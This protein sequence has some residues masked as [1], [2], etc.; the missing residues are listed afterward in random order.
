MSVIK[1][2]R[3][4]SYYVVI[5]F[6][7]AYILS[8][9][10]RMVLTIVVDKIK[11]DLA[12][13]EV[14]VSLLLGF[15]FAVSYII[16]GIPFGRWADSRS[17]V[18]LITFGIT[19][20]TIATVACGFAGSFW[21]LFVARIFVGFGEAAL[22]PAVYSLL[23]DYFRRDRVGFAMAIFASGT[24]VGGGLGLLTAGHIIEQFSLG[25]FALPMLPNIKSWQFAFIAVAIPGLVVAPLVW[26]TIREPARLGTKVGERGAKPREVLGYMWN[27]RASVVP[28]FLGF[29]IYGTVI[30]GY[31]VWGP[32]YF[33]RVHG[34]S[35]AE[36]GQVI[37]ITLLVM[38]TVG[39]LAGGAFHDKL[40]RLGNVDASTRLAL[41]AMGFSIPAIVPAYLADSTKTAVICFG[42]GV[43]CAKSILPLQPAMLRALFPSHMRG[44]ASAIYIGVVTLFGL[45]IGPTLIAFLTD[46]VFSGIADTGRSL[47]TASVGSAIIGSGLIF[48]ALPHVRKQMIVISELEASYDQD[49]IKIA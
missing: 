17:R 2:S 15:S 33:M 20:W 16:M 28:T 37:G 36:V 41:Y 10:D 40:V 27:N 21:H 29:S 3:A 23:P 35:V 4:Y 11:I 13:T 48:Y 18:G 14:Q 5:I 24:T 44:Q 47:A 7:V 30:Y 22:S 25:A 12:L 38:G 8:Y 6:L 46:H 1:H 43:L 34:M 26:L 19:I 32:A 39:N 9:V 42:I 45:G 31:G 49:Q